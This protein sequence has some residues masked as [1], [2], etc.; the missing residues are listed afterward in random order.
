VKAVL[1]LIDN[2]DMQLTLSKNIAKMAIPNAAELIVD[3][4]LKLKKI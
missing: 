3:E 4:L 2:E 1:D